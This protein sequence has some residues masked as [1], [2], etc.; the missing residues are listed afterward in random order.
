[1]AVIRKITPDGVVSTLFEN[2]QV[3][4]FFENIQNTG[5]FFFIN[6]IAV[7]SAGNLYLTGLG[8]TV[9]MA[10]PAGV[11]SVLAGNRGIGSINGPGNLARF[12][13]PSDLAL[14]NE[15]NVYVADMGNNMVRKITPA[16]NVTTIA[17]P[18]DL[19]GPGGIAIDNQGNMYV[20]DNTSPNN[21]VNAN[22]I[23]KIGLQ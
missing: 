16:G 12:Y 18:A 2:S 11:M 7:D 1:M 23:L 3:S 8:A 21:V 22:L 4:A 5:P 19:S 20:A 14:D 6:A 15:G 17:G 13:D 10:T 9:F